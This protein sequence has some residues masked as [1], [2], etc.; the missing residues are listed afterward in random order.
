MHRF[1]KVFAVLIL[2]LL[3]ALSIIAIACTPASPANKEAPSPAASSTPAGA[4]SLPPTPPGMINTAMGPISPDQLGVTLVHE[5]FCFAYPGWFADATIAPYNR[6]AALQ[7]GLKV[8]ETLKSI[9]VKTVIDPTPNDTGGR[10]PLLYKE[11]SKR[12]GINIICTSG[13]YTEKEGSPAYWETR[14]PFG[15][16]I[17]KMISDMFIKE[18]TEGIG[19]T[20]V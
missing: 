19:T 12:T 11:L 17:S 7:T 14:L 16:D 4:V 18:I 9:G 10:D 3:L 5:H 13:L 2:S 15:T 1:T 20:G 6:E 8:C